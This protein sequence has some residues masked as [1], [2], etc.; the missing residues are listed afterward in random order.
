[1]FLLLDANVIVG[2]P[3]LRGRQWDAVADAVASE[4]LDLYVPELAVD[5]AVARYRD[6]AALREREA[7]KALKT[8]PPRSRELVQEAINASES[9]AAEYESLLRARLE[10]MGAEI[11]G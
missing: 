10:Q 11:V 1:V 8:W 5:E 6:S 2:N 9:F 4:A 7:K 3:L